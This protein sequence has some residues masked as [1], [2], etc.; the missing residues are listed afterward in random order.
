MTHLTSSQLSGDSGASSGGAVKC[1]AGTVTVPIY[2]TVCVTSL[3][4]KAPLVRWQPIE[5]RVVYLQRHALT[6]AG[7]SQK[8]AV[9]DGYR[10]TRVVCS[11][12]TVA[13]PAHGLADVDQLIFF[14]FFPAL[15][16]PHL[17]GQV[18]DVCLVSVLS[19]TG[20]SHRV[21]VVREQSLVQTARHQSHVLQ[22][23]ACIFLPA[24]S[25]SN[26]IDGCY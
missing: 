13:L 17:K 19:G 24:P 9:A 10:S 16:T 11:T 8:V 22:A 2:T 3:Q 18:Y 23:A 5:H 14:F 25:A 15:P 4:I 7:S 21:R 12:Q 6:R 20:P 26:T 1:I